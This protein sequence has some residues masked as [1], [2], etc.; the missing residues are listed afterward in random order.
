M[1]NE[2]N[3]YIRNKFKILTL[4]CYEKTRTLLRNFLVQKSTCFG[5]KTN[6]SLERLSDNRFSLKAYQPQRNEFKTLF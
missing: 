5:Q 3:N 6:Y 4:N 1:E 2:Q